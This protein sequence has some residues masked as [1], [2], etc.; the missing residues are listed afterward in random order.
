MNIV[1]VF[2]VYESDKRK[3]KSSAIINDTHALTGIHKHAYIC[4]R[5]TFYVFAELQ[6]YR[7]FRIMPTP[8]KTNQS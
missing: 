6:V 7:L 5:A 4:T 2:S 8:L 3:I 1:P